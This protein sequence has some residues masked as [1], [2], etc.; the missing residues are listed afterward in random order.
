VRPVSW[1]WLWWDVDFLAHRADGAEL[2]LAE[3]GAGGDPVVFG[4]AG[5]LVTLRLL[6]QNND[7]RY[8]ETQANNNVHGY[9]NSVE[10]THAPVVGL[11]TFSELLLRNKRA[12]IRCCE[13][14]CE[15]H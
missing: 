12:E 4:A 3:A 13:R 14:T 2:D 1:C 15:N 7:A 6:H 5:M 8:E 11:I 9:A 10:P